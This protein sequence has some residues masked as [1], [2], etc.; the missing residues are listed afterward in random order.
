[1]GWLCTAGP[2]PHWQ[3]TA[4]PFLPRR[5]PS[6]CPEALLTLIPSP[7]VLG[8]ARPRRPEVPSVLQCVKILT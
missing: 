1:M 3:E 6:Q 2:A 4:P 7:T 5:G 8:A